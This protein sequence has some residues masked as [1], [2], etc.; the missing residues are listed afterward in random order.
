M[1]TAAS[2]VMALLVSFGSYWMFSDP[3]IVEALKMAFFACFGL[4][5]FALIWMYLRDFLVWLGATYNRRRNAKA[6]PKVFDLKPSER[7][8]L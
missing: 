4:F 2:F 8:R 3:G 1:K 7:W 6:P 5:C